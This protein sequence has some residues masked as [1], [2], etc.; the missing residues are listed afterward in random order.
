MEPQIV[1]VVYLANLG[2]AI[3]LEKC[4]NMFPSW[5]TIP[6]QAGI[7]HI[8]VKMNHIEGINTTNIIGVAMYQNGDISLCGFTN[9]T[10]I[11]DVWSY[12]KKILSSC[13]I[14]DQNN[15]M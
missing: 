6:A 3:D 10:L 12:V 7:P 15:E 4:K 9:T 11:N 1:N 2:F 14:E 5:T 8:D 13:R